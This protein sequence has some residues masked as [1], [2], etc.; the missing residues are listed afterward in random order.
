MNDDVIA[1]F[2]NIL[3][4]HRKEIEAFQKEKL[5]V[6]DDID[7]CLINILHTRRHLHELEMIKQAKQQEK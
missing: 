4:L 5:Q 3:S 2:E 7:M 6:Q 1:Q